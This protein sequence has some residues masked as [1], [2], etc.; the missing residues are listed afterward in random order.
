[1]SSSQSSPREE[2]K[3]SKKKNPLAMPISEAD[4]HADLK[5]KSQNFVLEKKD[6]VSTPNSKSLVETEERLPTEGEIENANNTAKG[7]VQA[8]IS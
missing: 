3:K 1:V 4:P 5:R 8:I 6:L 2:K 7:Y